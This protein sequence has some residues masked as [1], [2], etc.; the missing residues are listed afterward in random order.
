MPL[1]VAPVVSAVANLK[2]KRWT[3]SALVD[4]VATTTPLVR[5]TSERATLAKPGSLATTPCTPLPSASSQMRS[6]IASVGRKPKSIDVTFE[7]LHERCQQ[8]RRKEIASIAPSADRDARLARAAHSVEDAVRVERAVAALRRRHALQADERRLR[9]AHRDKV[10]VARPQRVL[11]RLE[12]V[13][14]ARVGRRELHHGAR[15][16]DERHDDARDAVLAGVLATP[17][18]TKHNSGAP[19]RRT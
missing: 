6:P 12:S 8:R 13:E 16:V 19:T 10:R 9:V 18:Q 5:L 3:H 17:S 4:V 1:R 11:Q 15:V 2:P 7:P 14:A